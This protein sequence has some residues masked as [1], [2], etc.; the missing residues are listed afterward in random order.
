M[1]IK[2]N[3]NKI[4]LIRMA[5]IKNKNLIIPSAINDTKQF[6]LSHVV[7]GN[8]KMMQTLWKSLAVLIK[9]QYI[10]YTT[11]DSHF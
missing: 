10:Q 4:L 9:L 2:T 1:E 3:C 5:E 11:Q 6:E 8:E 7:G